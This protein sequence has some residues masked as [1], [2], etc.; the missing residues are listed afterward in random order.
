MSITLSLALLLS[1][2]TL[3]T[4]NF[5]QVINEKAVFGEFL[6]FEDHVI[7]LQ[8]PSKAKVNEPVEFVVE[9]VSLEDFVPGKLL[10][11]HSRA[12][13]SQVRF[14]QEWTNKEFRSVVYF[15]AA[16]PGEYYILIVKQSSTLKWG[17]G[18]ILVE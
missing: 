1:A 18:K 9:G 13:S 12:D 6:P 7:E 17:C 14:V 15:R 5:T 10:F 8:G 2:Q 16:K 4:Q 3:H 11:W